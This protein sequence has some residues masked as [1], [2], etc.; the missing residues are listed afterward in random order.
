MRAASSVLVTGQVCDPIMPGSNPVLK[1][2]PQ[3]TDQLIEPSSSLPM[4]RSFR[5]ALIDI[6]DRC[7]P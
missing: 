4:T 3:A 7:R 6:R 1:N 2:G 5:E